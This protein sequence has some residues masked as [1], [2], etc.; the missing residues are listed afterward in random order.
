LSFSQ[1]ELPKE[2]ADSL[3]R[4][5]TDASEPDTSR[6][7]A[8]H[9]YARDGY[10]FSQ[11]DSAYYYAQ[12]Q[13]DYAKEKNLKKDMA[14]ALNTQGLSFYVMGDYERAI[15]LYTQSLKLREEIGDKKGA[16]GSLSNIGILY[17]YMGNYPEAIDY[18]TRCLKLDEETKNRKG[19][20]HSLNNLGSVYNA[21]GDYSI[22]LDFLARCVS[23]YE[24]LGDQNAL[25]APLNNIGVAHKSLGDYG[26]AL[27][28]YTRSLKIGE[29]TGNMQGTANALSNIGTIYYNQG[30]NAKAMDY[31]MQCLKI[32]EETG[33]NR[34]MAYSFGS[35]GNV[36]KSQRNYAQA[37]DY[38]KRSLDIASAMGDKRIVAA[39]LSNL[40]IVSGHQADSALKAG[41]Y[42][43]S[44]EK[45][46]RALEY[47][48][49]G[50]KIRSEIGD[51]EG[52]AG[53]A[54]NLATV[55]LAQSKIALASDDKDL[56]KTLNKQA[57]ESAQQ[58]LKMALEIGE[59]YQTKLASKI[60]FVVHI[61]ENDLPRADEYLQQI[62]TLAEKDL[63]I[64]YFILSENEKELYFSSMEE[65]FNAFYEFTLLY[66]DSFVGYTDTCYNLALRN[67]GLTLKSSTLM[68][69]VVL[70]SGDS[71]LIAQYEAW[72]DL[73]EKI[74]KSYEAAENTEILETQ[75]NE[76]EKELVSKS[77]AFSD[78]DK[79][80]KL[81][82]KQVQ[83]GL[84]PTEAAIEFISF[85]SALD[86]EKPIR[87]AALVIKPE[88]KH[89]EIVS[90]CTEDELKEI[91]GTF[92]SSNFNFVSK[93]YGSKQE[94]QTGLYTKVW[95][96]LEKYLGGI[97]TIHYSPSGLLHKISFSAL[98][99]DQNILLSDSYELHQHN[100]TGRVALPDESSFT[101]NDHFLVAGGVH[102]NTAATA[103]EIWNYLP[104]TE[105]E[106]QDISTILKE[107][108]HSIGYLTGEQVTEESIKQQLPD[109]SVIHIAT[110]GFFFPD[111]EKVNEEIKTETTQENEDLTFR[112]YVMS[113]SKGTTNYAHWSFVNNK[114][115]LM[116]SGLVLAK[117]N[118][119]WH[120]DAM[121]EG[122]DGILTA[123]EV[124]NID[125]HNTSLV[126]LSACETG[127]GD[128]KGSEG[129][130]GLQRA[131]KIAG[132]KYVMMSLWQVP[133]KETA[134]FMTTFYRNLTTTGDVR[135]SF[136]TT[137]RV[138]R[139][140][141]DPYYWAAFV[142]VE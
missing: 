76:L 82:W 67:K 79:V 5:W 98:S 93:V 142:L 20:A 128:I 71:L 99:K 87:Y 50:M 69:K 116:R 7:Q 8:I 138:L 13:Y 32:D 17:Y 89:P 52:V 141:Y 74:A 9:Q 126:V 16:A 134:E 120:R 62:K 78:F 34:G 6:L 77:A 55:Y 29:I 36:H 43:L 35:I 113:H 125:M 53:S 19:V 95:Q 25:M 92:Q 121:A 90:L 80:K 14:E 59:A 86:A 51:K 46:A 4:A 38:F 139:Q 22:A 26:K 21:K 28:Y 106:I 107:K 24:E 94:A 130:Y 101:A 111:P 48:T 63:S 129:V 137:Q 11:P 54:G 109:A 30:D 23:I 112:G 119:I 127:L 15:E 135:K 10:L 66:G 27:Q 37:V 68:R 73:K 114:N 102:Y 33:D 61:L 40:G 115:P 31:Y 70:N 88:S 123:Q 133:D 75:A 39:N 2:V 47:F 81:D 124:A 83:A 41:N 44:S 118:D 96:P 117:A 91:L 49:E 105:K 131:F 65:D 122:E 140:K 60:C 12:L 110:H 42:S 56:S 57:L 104:G 84:K 45:Y 18:H 85:P 64:N 3:W 108:E 100:S 1:S 136:N 72:R 97:K 58:S 132:V 103:T